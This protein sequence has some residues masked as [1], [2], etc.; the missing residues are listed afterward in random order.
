MSSE[1]LLLADMLRVDAQRLDV[2]YRPTRF[3]DLETIKRRTGQ[4]LVPNDRR[5]ID[6]GRLV[7]HCYVPR[8]QISGSPGAIC[9]RRSTGRRTLLGHGHAHAWASHLRGEVVFI[10]E[11]AIRW[12]T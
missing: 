7:A 11:T 3:G 6:G 8:R 2:E 4:H 5:R 9:R 10:T 12:V 1:S